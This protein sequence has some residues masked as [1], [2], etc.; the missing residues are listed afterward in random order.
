MA[1]GLVSLTAPNLKETWQGLQIEESIF[2]IPMVGLL[3]IV[4]ATPAP[5]V[6]ALLTDLCTYQAH[7]CL[8]E[9]EARNTRRAIAQSMPGMLGLTT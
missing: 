5:V 7:H 2:S 6:A 9:V 8:G 1:A 4:E 3:R